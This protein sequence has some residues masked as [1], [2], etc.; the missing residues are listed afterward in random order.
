MFKRSGHFISRAGS[1]IHQFSVFP[2]TDECLR[3]NCSADETFTFEKHRR[4]R[5]MHARKFAPRILFT[6]RF[7]NATLF[8]ALVDSRN[9]SKPHRAKATSRKFGLVTLYVSIDWRVS[10]NRNEL[11]TVLHARLNRSDGPGTLSR[12]SLATVSRRRLLGNDEEKKRLHLV[13]SLT[14]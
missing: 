14:V 5:G 6:Y 8:S 7:R 2:L 13:R 4:P 11:T 1:L 10:R 12:D 9:R 3:A